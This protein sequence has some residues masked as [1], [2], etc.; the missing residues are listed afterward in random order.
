MENFKMD[1]KAFVDE[2]NQY[3]GCVV[4]YQSL[5]IMY[6]CLNPNVVHMMESYN[7][8]K[9]FMR[10]YEEDVANMPSEK[11]HP[12]MKEFKRRCTETLLELFDN[13]HI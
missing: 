6:I 11:D 8:F 5:F 4:A 3:K 13:H 10:S 9:Q 12:N 2:I 7:N 1:F